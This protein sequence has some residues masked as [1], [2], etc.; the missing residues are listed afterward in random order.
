MGHK[1]STKRRH[2][3][4]SLA[5]LFTSLQFF[6]FSDA[7]LWTDLRHVCFGLP[8]LFPS[9]LE[10]KASVSMASF[11]FLRLCP[12]QVH[13]RRFYL[14]GYL[15]FPLPFSRVLHLKSLYTKGKGETS[16]CDEDAQ[17]KGVK[18]ISHN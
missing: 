12:I 14:Y 10:S 15:G 9:G 6:P 8:V 5:I 17:N 7:S 18:A 11:P 3:A 16:C 4:L 13:F 2:L 1:A